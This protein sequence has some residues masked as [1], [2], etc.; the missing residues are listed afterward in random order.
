MPDEPK[1]THIVALVVQPNGWFTFYNHTTGELKYNLDPRSGQE[2]WESLIM[3]V[4]NK[5]G[6]DAAR[7]LKEAGEA[8]MP[9]RSEVTRR[10]EPSQDPQDGG[11]DQG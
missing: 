2:A 10:R 8:D 5:V 9:V 4:G 6:E 3:L 11:S 1:Q 7:L